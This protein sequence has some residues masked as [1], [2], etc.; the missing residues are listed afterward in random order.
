MFD[1][2]WGDLEL[3]AFTLGVALLLVLPLQLVLCFKVRRRALRLLPA[4]LFAGTAVVFLLMSAA[5]SNW[6][7]V[8]YLVLAIFNGIL[9]AACGL[10]W[11]IWAVARRSKRSR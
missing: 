5:V 4:A 1:V 10:G 9:L 8:F 2:H 6:T 7:G 3:T 11:G